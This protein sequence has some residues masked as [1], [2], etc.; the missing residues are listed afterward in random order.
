M[1]S[2]ARASLSRAVDGRGFNSM[3][4]GMAL[5]ALTLPMVALVTPAEAQT[6]SDRVEEEVIVSAQKYDQRLQDVPVP[7]TAVDAQMLVSS[8]QLRLQDYY[9]SIPGLNLTIG[10]NTGAPFISIRGVTT[11]GLINPTVGFVVDD[12]P[13]GTSTVGS[14]GGNV[15]YDFDPS[16]L[17]R[18]EV[19]RGPQ[20]TLYGANS[21]GGLL[22]YVTVDPSTEAMTGTVNLG[23]SSVHGG[24]EI[25]YSA[26]GS[27]NIPLSNTLA[28]RASGSTRR[29]PGYIDNLQT[30]QEDVNRTDAMSGRI[31][32]LWRPSENFSVKL[33]ALYQNIERDGSADV[34]LPS[35]IGP[36]P[37]LGDLEQSALINTGVYE[38]TYQAYSLTV[39]AKVGS[40]DLISLT[41]YGVS[42]NRQLTDRTS[43]SA[44]AQRTF[45]VA[46]AVQKS[47]SRTP[48]FSQ[49]L[50]WTTALGERVDWLL[51]AFYTRERYPSHPEVL[52]V[53]PSNG[54]V[55][56]LL[57]HADNQGSY[58]E[59]SA[60]TNVTIRI[61]DRFD[62]QLGGR[63]SRHSVDSGPIVA[64]VSPLFPTGSFTPRF[65]SEDDAFTYLITPKFQLTDDVMVYARLA[66]GYRPGGPNTS[67]SALAAGLPREYGADTT[68]NYEVGAK[69]DLFDG[70]MSFDASI[71]H[72]AW[73]DVQLQLQDP[74]N[75]LLVY[76]L[77]AGEAR[78]RG[79]ELALDLRAADALTISAW[80]AYND[81]ELTQV[82][83]NSVLTARA[84][85]TLP[86]GARESGSVSVNYEFPV[87]STATAFAGTSVSYV[88]ERKGRFFTGLPQETFPAYTQINLTAGASLASWTL[89]A[90]ANNVT[91]RRGV[92]RSGRDGAFITY[93]VTY[94]QPRTVGLSLTKEF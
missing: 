71:Y 92:L 94:I 22:K 40:G 82:P 18:L 83:T 65:T 88:G 35:P 80:G 14:G 33:S 36:R 26:R 55:V 34:H 49:E 66:S 5:G 93:A 1:K 7:V 70:F 25:G 63:A 59:H 9:S 47:D 32:A 84:G 28:I 87:G 6:R 68:Q 29:D 74:A 44:L 41:G 56:G 11:G 69:G 81:A 27:V 12:V 45:G 76:T 53:N 31:A 39:K 4:R 62:L 86:Y 10:G 58:E 60:F 38:D 17:A 16:E 67:P 42:D 51:G 90:F 13:F 23:T 3:K 89:N 73:K 57:T 43:L 72:I 50:R 19:L 77:N 54:A 2:S 52:A 64:S 24:D 46:G 30:G 21:L 15:A 91:D 48:R 75:V 20:G 78:S 61:T 37:D 79:V 85:D 8:S